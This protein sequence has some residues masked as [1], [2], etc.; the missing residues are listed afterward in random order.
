[1]KHVLF[2]LVLTIG[3]STWAKNP[4]VCGAG[5]TQN[6]EFCQRMKH[7]RATSNLVDSQRILMNVDYD[8]LGQLATSL[9]NNAQTLIQLAPASLQNHTAGL[10]KIQMM[11]QEMGRLAEL[12]NPNA[13]VVANNFRRQCLNCHNSNNPDPNI[14]WNEIFSFNWEKVTRDCSTENR[15]PYLCISMNALGSN[16]NHVVT[17]YVANIQDYSVTASVANEIVRILRKLKTLNFSHFT[18]ESRA[19]AEQSALNVIQLANAKDP[20]T[21]D[22]ARN[23]NQA[24]M[25]CHNSI[26]VNEIR[27]PQH[28]FSTKTNWLTK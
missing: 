16:L 9:D 25:Q 27:Q 6:L 7:L 2:F 8:F 19:F 17:A 5:N 24:C 10:Q 12:K 22:M 11:A 1:M 28:A 20:N 21:F 4:S 14:I 26:V 15:N 23:L 18:E 3:V 13:M